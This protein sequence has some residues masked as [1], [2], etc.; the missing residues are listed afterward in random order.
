[1]GGGRGWGAM[2]VGGSIHLLT[3]EIILR[4]VIATL[5]VAAV[6]VPACVKRPASGGLVRGREMRGWVVRDG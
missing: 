3:T 2:G 4:V 1:M 5:A 6:A